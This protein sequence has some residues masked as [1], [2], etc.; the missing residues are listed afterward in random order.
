MYTEDN[1]LEHYIDGYDTSRSN[2]MRFVNPAMTAESQNLV[3]CQHNVSKWR[4]YWYM[5]KYILNYKI[6]NLF[7]GFET[8][9]VLLLTIADFFLSS[10]RFFSSRRELWSETRSFSFGTARSSQRDSTTPPLPAK[11][12]RESVSVPLLMW[13][14][15]TISNI[16]YSNESL[17]MKVIDKPALLKKEFLSIAVEPSFADLSKMLLFCCRKQLRPHGGRNCAGRSE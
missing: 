12:Y 10:R 16:T 1:E 8:Q 14:T 6:I 3:A 11:W 2:W 5:Y 13:L 7:A 4:I 17:Q 9:C 15:S